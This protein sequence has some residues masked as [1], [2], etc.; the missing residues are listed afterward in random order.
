MSIEL[1]T[2]KEEYGCYPYCQTYGELIE[3]L[4]TTFEHGLSEKEL[5]IIN[6]V[7]RLDKLPESIK[8]KLA[9]IVYIDQNFKEIV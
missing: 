1:E 9:K 7:T 3:L 8:E 2:L 4:E 5:E 6:G